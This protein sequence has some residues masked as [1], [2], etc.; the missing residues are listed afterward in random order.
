MLISNVCLCFAFYIVITPVNLSSS[1]IL[2]V[3]KTNNQIKKHL[4]IF[5]KI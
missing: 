2:N 4:M 3:V 1:I 5:K